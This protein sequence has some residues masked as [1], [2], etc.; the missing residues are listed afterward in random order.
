MPASYQ[1]PMRKD[2][3]K[4]RT[5]SQ[6]V[7]SNTG[8]EFLTVA[9]VLEG[10]VGTVFSITPD[11]TLGQAVQALKEKGIGALIV[12][13]AGGKLCVILSERDIVRKLGLDEKYGFRIGPA[14]ISAAAISV[15]PSRAA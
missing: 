6:S 10:K 9:H 5:S 2:S 14:A 7:S 8:S 1:A 13:D 15:K 12:T 3:E 11:E 4:K